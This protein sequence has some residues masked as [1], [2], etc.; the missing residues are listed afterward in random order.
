MLT[1]AGKTAEA[2]L[3]LSE[4]FDMARKTGFAMDDLTAGKLR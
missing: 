1:E 4:L 2:Q 3:N